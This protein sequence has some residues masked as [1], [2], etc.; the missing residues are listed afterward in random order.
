VF[1]LSG[2]HVEI[3]FGR[4]HRQV[5]GHDTALLLVNMGFK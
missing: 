4:V 1:F 2:F 5:E 3:I